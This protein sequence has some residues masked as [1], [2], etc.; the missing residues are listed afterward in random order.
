MELRRR[1]IEEDKHIKRFKV[2]YE[3]Y[4]LEQQLKEYDKDIKNIQS[5]KIMLQDL[6]IDTPAMTNMINLLEAVSREFQ[7]IKNQLMLN[8]RLGCMEI[9]YKIDT[10]LR[11]QNFLN[12]HHLPSGITLP[13]ISNPHMY[14]MMVLEKLLDHYIDMRG[15]ME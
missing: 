3:G 4:K 12:V 14:F 6:K 5:F 9:E 8:E 10:L 1:S 11:F 15:L 2:D 7:H 13:N